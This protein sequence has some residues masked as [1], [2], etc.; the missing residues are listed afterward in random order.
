MQIRVGTS[1]NQSVTVRWGIIKERYAWYGRK[2]YFKWYNKVGYGSG[3]IAG[4]VV[5]RHL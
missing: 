4:N 2:K 1:M 3:D 5:Y